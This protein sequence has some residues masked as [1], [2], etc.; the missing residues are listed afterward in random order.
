M[1]R[2]GGFLFSWSGEV[3]RRSYAI[4]GVS[5]FFLKWN[6]DRFLTNNFPPYID[7]D[8]HRILLPLAYLLPGQ[9]WNEITDENRITLLALLGFALPFIY[10]GVVLTIKRLR[11]LGWPSWLAVLFFAPFINLLFFL[12]LSLQPGRETFPDKSSGKASGR[13][14]AWF[15]RMIPR[16]N[17]ACAFVACVFS[18]LSMVGIIVF[19]LYLPLFESYGWGF[20]VGLPFAMGVVAAITYGHHVERTLG[21]SFGVAALATAF[22]FLF[23]FLLAFEGI[24]CLVMAAPIAFPLALLGGAVGHL[25]QRRP[26]HGNP[27]IA[28]LLAAFFLM[29]F[30]K[31]VEPEAPLFAV[32][33]ETV[34]DAPPETV[35]RHVVSFSELP[36]PE[37]WLFKAGVACPTHAKIEGQGVGA[38]RR[39]VFT[40]GAFVEP[41]TVWDEPRILAFDVIEQPPPMKELYPYDI[42]PPHLDGHLQ[43]ERG[44]FR[45]VALPGGRTRLVGTTWYRHNMWPAN[46]WQTWSDFLIHRIH[47]RVL[48]HVKK[49]AE[50]D[51]SLPNPG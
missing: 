13:L 27:S 30:E 43:S 28:I 46:Y 51:G 29:G 1:R 26:R 40:T 9:G 15:D 11:S 21:A 14:N 20:F 50:R 34:I 45:L 3:G 49:L 17:L 24:I 48:R 5:L 47:A 6:L 44:E 25:V 16:S 19:S 4:A 41:I 22:A 35:W 33:S 31:A 18:A 8:N 37:D 38:V 7:F 10:L 42:H 12:L 32:R 39:C 36:P 23:L 2:L